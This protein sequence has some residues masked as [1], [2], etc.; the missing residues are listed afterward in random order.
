ML[1]S[2]M[3][4][5]ASHQS[6]ASLQPRGNIGNFA[7]HQECGNLSMNLI[8]RSFKLEIEVSKREGYSCRKR[9]CG[10]IQASSANNPISTPLTGTNKDPSKKSSMVS[11][12]I[13]MSCF[14]SQESMHDTSTHTC[15]WIAFPLHQN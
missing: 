5:M 8:R 12:Q 11:C 14:Y 10:S 15:T 2:R 3:V 4:A 1:I 9:S 6:I 7:L 13:I